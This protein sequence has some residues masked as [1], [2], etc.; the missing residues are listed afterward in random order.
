MIIN[1]NCTILE[2]KLS[3]LRDTLEKMLQELI[4]IFDAKWI[5]PGIVIVEL[6]PQSNVIIYSN[7]SEVKKLF[8]FMG[9]V[10]NEELINKDYSRLIGAKLNIDLLNLENSTYDLPTIYKEIKMMEE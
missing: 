6:T 10:T 9:V 7:D 4:I 3:I 2:L 8:K 1:F 5:K